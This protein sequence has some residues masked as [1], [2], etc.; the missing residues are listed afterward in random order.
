MV[1]RKVRS[2][3]GLFAIWEMADYRQLFGFRV[4]SLA[5]RNDF[6]WP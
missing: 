4:I 5:E 6:N 3:I 2:S 1:L